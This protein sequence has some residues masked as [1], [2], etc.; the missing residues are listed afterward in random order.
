MKTFNTF[1]C[2]SPRLLFIAIVVFLGLPLTNI[3]A[4]E[5][6][7]FNLTLLKSLYPDHVRGDRDFGGNGPSVNT[8]VR[9]RISSDKRRLEAVIY[10]K[11]KETRSNWTE[12]KKNWT[13]TVASAPAGYEFT[14]I[15]SSTYSC[16]NYVDRDHNMD[17]PNVGCGNLVHKIAI[18]GDTGGDDVGN[19]TS[20]DTRIHYI[21]FNPARAQIQRIAGRKQEIDQSVWLRKLQTTFRETSIR[22]NNY[23]PR[24]FKNSKE[25]EYA[26]YQANDSYIRTIHN[27]RPFIYRFTIPVERRDPLSIYITDMKTQRVSAVRSG[28]QIKLSLFFESNGREVWSNCVANG[29]CGAYGNRDIQMNSAKVDVYLRPIVERGRF[30]YRCEK[31]ELNS[32]TR[33][34]GCNND[35]FAFMCDIFMPNGKSRIKT[36]VES[37]LK[38]K[39]NNTAIKATL[40]TVLQQQLG[41]TGRITDTYID[42]RTGKL[43]IIK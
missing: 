36:S 25:E 11:A 24:R 18:K 2:P 32:T 4:Q 30:S 28:N 43:V 34:D 29:G 21:Q 35:L 12:G 33:I 31:V 9:L 13:K 37:S 22:L 42:S 1:N 16:A 40:N 5:T 19:T 8:T 17:F 27:G 14:R 23:T 3:E 7:T 38:S 10:F 26:Y 6:R 39:L 41:A 15:L 20:D